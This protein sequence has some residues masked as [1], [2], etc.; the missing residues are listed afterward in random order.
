LHESTE[1]E[2]IVTHGLCTQVV[3]FPFLA[4]T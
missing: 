1:T 3:S 2:T 4:S